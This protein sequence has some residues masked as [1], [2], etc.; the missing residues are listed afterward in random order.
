MEP[1]GDG[2]VRRVAANRQHGRA[3][4]SL[5]LHLLVLHL[6]AAF[7]GNRIHAVAIHGIPELVA[8]KG[9]PPEI[10]KRLNEAVNKIQAEDE[11]KKYFAA[12]GMLAR[13]SSPVEFGKVV[14][15]DYVRWTNV[16]ERIEF[17]PD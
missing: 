16:V 17:K 6:L 12:Q 5:L 4:S 9:T 1:A 11:V 15:E 7:H 2:S 13:G 14:R 8:P 10:V 3:R